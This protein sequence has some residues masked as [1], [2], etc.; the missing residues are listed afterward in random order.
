M[1][2][3]Q[4]IVRKLGRVD[5]QETLT[6]MREFTRNRGDGIADEIWLLEHS[7]VYTQ[8]YS[9]KL[10]PNIPTDIPVIATDR[11]GQITYHGPGQLI[12]YLLIDLRQRIMGIRKLVTSI[13]SAI[14]STLHHYQIDS[15]PVPKAPGVYAKKKKIASLGIRVNR[16][17][18]YHG[19]SL[20]VDMDTKPFDAI[21]VCGYQGLEVTTMRR[22]GAEC[23]MDQ[24]EI[25]CAEELLQKLGYEHISYV[26]GF[27]V[28]Q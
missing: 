18:T 17:C 4:V 11:G 8:G 5:Y 9:C 13:E 3:R 23:N 28:L 16:G 26:D 22:L 7:S 2:S 21:D 14:V 12:V 1:N 25:R 27:Q 24:I 19:L 20:N 6:R 15:Q 10:R